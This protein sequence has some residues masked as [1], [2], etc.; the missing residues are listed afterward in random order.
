VRVDENRCSRC[1]LVL[2]GSE[3]TEV[4]LI[5]RVRREGISAAVAA[6]ASVVPGR[7]GRARA[8]PLVSAVALM[9]AL[10][11][12]SVN[13]IRAL[14]TLGVGR[15]TDWPCV[16]SITFGGAALWGVAL[17]MLKQGAPLTPA[18]TSLLAAAAALSVANIE[19]C[20]TR[21]HGFTITVVL[22]HGVTTAVMLAFLTRVGFRALRWQ[23]P[24][25]GPRERP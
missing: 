12:G 22:W 7:G 6:F 16:L 21:G 8:I 5:D 24:T 20:I 15:E 13:D 11:W 1:R 19:V 3:A 25:A 10:A 9:A 2:L 18:T 14:S 17:V 4:Q 23:P